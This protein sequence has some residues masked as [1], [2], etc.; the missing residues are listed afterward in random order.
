MSEP[1]V[2]I[3]NGMAAARLVEEIASY[4]LGRYSIAVVGEEKGL[5][6]NRVLLSPL[7]GGEISE[8]DLELKP[9]SWWAKAGVTLIPGRAASLINRVRKCVQLADGTE[10]PYSKLVLATG[11]SPFRLPLPGIDKPGV[12]AFR[13]KADITRMMGHVGRNGRAIVIGGGLLG[14]EAAVGLAN[15]GARVTLV[16][17]MDRL[18]E[19]QLDARAAC[20]LKKALE[21]KGVSVMLEAQSEAIEGK[22]KAAGLTLK[23]GVCLTA[24]LI[25]SAVGISPRVELA[26][27]AEL[28]VKRG[29]VVNDQM[30]TSDEHIFALGECAEHRGTCYGLV[31]P[32]YDQA[33]VLAASL[34]GA[35]AA[36]EGSILST[37]LKVSGVPV[38]SSGDFMG[39][40]GTQSIVWDDPGLNLYRKLVLREGKLVGAVFFGETS[41]ALWYR[42]LIRSGQNVDS[43]RSELIFGRAYTEAA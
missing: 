8:A 10:I 17:L 19:R 27:A 43:M 5:A 12:T 14:I 34:C 38:F 39:A 26:K 16:H 11:S 32:A 2:I 33:R 4:G 42:D 23:S 21:E 22:S 3:G 36:Y 25:V 15:K 41:D 40:D 13:E 28:E 1:L 9:W 18:M 37:N 7:L 29:I 20:Y 24:D 35:K 31:E 30:Q 6:Y